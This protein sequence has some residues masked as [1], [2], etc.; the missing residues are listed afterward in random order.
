MIFLVWLNVAF[1]VCT[2]LL[3]DIS[4]PSLDVYHTIRVILEDYV[5]QH[6]MCRHKNNLRLHNPK[7]PVEDIQKDPGFEDCT[8]HTATAS[9]STVSY[10]R[11]P[12]ASPL[13]PSSTG[14]CFLDVVKLFYYSKNWSTCP[15][16][17]FALPQNTRQ[18]S[19]VMLQCCR[20]LHTL[21][22]M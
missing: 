11:F 6:I 5:L 7:I 1:S 15:L 19:F 8:L 18:H 16:F 17:T 20:N 4:A 9:C 13:S 3:I 2:T 12:D 21:Q 22:Q 10:T 14:T